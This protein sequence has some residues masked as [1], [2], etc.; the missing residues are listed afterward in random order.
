MTAKPVGEIKKIVSLIDRTE[1]DEVVYPKSND[2]TVFQP[3]SKPYHNF[4]QEAVVWPFA[5]SPAWGQRVTFSVPWPW[6]GD[7]L[8]WIALRLKPATWLP[9]DAYNR[10]GPDYLEWVPADPSQAWVWANSLGTAA[11]EHAAM[12]VDGVVIEEFSGDWLNVWNRGAH[13]ASR[14]A[15]FDD[16]IYASYA[17]QTYMNFRVS[18]DGYIYCYLPFAFSKFVNTAFPLVSC[19][20]PDTIRFHITLR[21]FHEVVRRLSAPTG[22]KETPINGSFVVRDL[23]FPFTKFQTVHNAFA[24]PGFEQADILCG[25]SSVEG[26][27]REAYMKSPHEIL[28]NPVVETSFN[29]PLKYVVNTGEADRVKLQLPITIANGPIKQLIFFLRRKASVDNYRDYNNYSATLTSEYDPTWK[30]YKPLLARA[31]LQVGTAIWADEGERWW[32]ASADI[33]LPGGV[34]AYGDYIYAYNF[35]EKPAEF[36]P[37]GSLN[38]SRVDLRLLL[39]VTPPGGASDLEWSVHVFVVGTNW[40]R[41]QNGLANMVFMD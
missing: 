29:E 37:S 3:D 31:Q 36:S 14:A 10:M 35:S 11:I 9:P 12:E 4:V 20:G 13:T 17:Q 5:G 27:L 23:T 30:P 28:L 34:R 16:G 6:Q 26:E 19:S 38:A 33:L 15:P 25:I 32:R 22:C 8:N 24:I 7:F 1:F 18:D 41:F 21:P 40:I 39:T 2:T